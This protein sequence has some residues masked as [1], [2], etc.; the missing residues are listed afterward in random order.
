MN[1]SLADNTRLSHY[2]LEKDIAE[3][4]SWPVVYAVA[5][6]LDELRNDPRFKDILKRLNLPE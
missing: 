4:S 3:R 1:K 5:P 6:E 2:W